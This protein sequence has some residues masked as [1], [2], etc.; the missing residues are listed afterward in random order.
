MRSVQKRSWYAA[1][2][3]L[4]ADCLLSLDGLLDAASL[5]LLQGVRTTGEEASSSGEGEHRRHF[6][7]EQLQG[8]DQA[9]QEQERGWVAA[10]TN[11]GEGNTAVNAPAGESQVGGIE[12]PGQQEEQQLFSLPSDAE[13]QL[14][15]ETAPRPAPND[16]GGHAASTLETALS[17]PGKDRRQP[18]AMAPVTATAHGAADE[19]AGA[20]TAAKETVTAGLEKAGETAAKLKAAP[21]EKGAGPVGTARV[22][23]QMVVNAVSGAAGAAAATAA[24]G[25]QAA[26][27]AFSAAVTGAPDVV[28]GVEFPGAEEEE[29]QEGM[30]GEQEV[31]RQEGKEQ[32]SKAGEEVVAEEYVAA[33]E[34]EAAAGGDQEAGPRKGAG[35][36]GEVEA[37]A[38][39]GPREAELE[40]ETLAQAEAPAEGAE[41]RSRVHCPS[42]CV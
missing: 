24:A 13:L 25:A 5:H 8:E 7:P 34:G 31:E 23:V 33:V 14:A 12:A 3:L 32:G 15:L 30:A 4:H 17:G 38:E 19:A 28:G 6:D 36:E 10:S 41:V 42:H 11:E 29:G 9:Q 16:S 40:A 39:T 18:T 22:S 2:P 21:G 20:G 35:E 27:E 37:E 1:A 26:S